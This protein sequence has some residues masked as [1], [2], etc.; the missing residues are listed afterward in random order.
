MFESLSDECRLPN[1]SLTVHDHKERFIGSLQTFYELQFGASV[2]KFHIVVTRIILLG[3]ILFK[4]IIAQRRQTSS[5][6]H[7]SDS[8]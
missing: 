1:A 5:S 8:M 6:M 7:F 4:I 2:E 3:I